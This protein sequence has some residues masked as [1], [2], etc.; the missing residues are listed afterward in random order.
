MAACTV[1]VEAGSE[2]KGGVRAGVMV[3]SVYGDK[4]V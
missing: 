3:G 2:W 4:S 1:K